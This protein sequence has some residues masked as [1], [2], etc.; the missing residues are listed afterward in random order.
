MIIPVT[1]IILVSV[2]CQW[3]SWRIKQPAIIFLLL[4][5][6]IAGPVTGRLDPD[7][8][9]GDFLPS[10]ISLSVAV[11]LFEGSL[12]LRFHDIAGLERVVRNMVSIGMGIT[13]IITSIT[14][15]IVL[16]FSWEISFLFGAVMVVTGPTVIVPILRTVRPVASVANILRW[17]GIIIDPL[18]AVLAVL[19]FGFIIAGGGKAAWG[20]V[21]VSFGSILLVGAI[22]GS[23][24]GFLTGIVLRRHWLP[25]YLHNVAV[26]AFVLGLFALSNYL[27]IESGLITVTVMGIWLTN[28]RNINV[29]DII[30]F[31]ES[32]SILLISVL[33]IVLAARIEFSE[34]MQ[35]GWATILIYISV[36]F[37]SRPLDVLISSYGSA[38]SWREKALIAWIAPRGIVAAAITALFALR[39]EI[40]G[41]HEASFLVPLVFLIIIATV[42][43]QSITARP[44][45]RLLGVAEP[46]PR[47]FL[48]IGANILARRISK[49]LEQNGFRT[50]L[51][52]QYWN[53]IIKARMEGL[54]TYYGNP[55]SEHAERHLDLVGI[56]RMLALTPDADFNVLSN[57]HYRMEFGPGEVFC[58]QTRPISIA[59]DKYRPSVRHRGNPLF[60]E[61][62]TYDIL[63]NMLE[64]GAEIR[65][66]KLTE[67]FDYAD[68]QRRY[69]GRVIPLFVIDKGYNLR[70][71]TAFNEIMPKPGWSV[72]GIVPAEI[73]QKN[74]DQQEGKK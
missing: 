65:T 46:E 57:I 56:G 18:G 55:I 29:E 4:A 16:G 13:W 64:K 66:T 21:I 2:V 37:I 34:I 61:D 51:I 1:L 23:A 22:L 26:L 24:G 45:A 27:R 40:A 41:H 17:E 5:G 25:L 48:I 54:S 9:F 3:I 59:S 36:Q 70:V 6:I 73:G 10:F 35:L 28:M 52:D 43:P 31:K 14:T 50:L 42:V 68:Y 15:H 49:S 33:F 69:A 11:I 63:T 60:R 30:D 38:L 72:I 12:T 39:L 19:V 67:N 47:G 58:I 71:F 32:L 7:V 74:K 44:F 8:L 62:V 20:Q 53:D